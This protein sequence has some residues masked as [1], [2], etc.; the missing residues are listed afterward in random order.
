[1]DTSKTVNEL[2][3]IVKN[4]HSVGIFLCLD[5]VKHN[6]YTRNGAIEYVETIQEAVEKMKY[7]YSI[8]RPGE[9]L[10]LNYLYNLEENREPRHI[11]ISMAGVWSKY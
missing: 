11:E 2:V 6:F 7:V 4:A 1:M 9:K 10:K 3:Y 8:P 5:Y